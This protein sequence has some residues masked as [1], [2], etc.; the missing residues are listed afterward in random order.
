[1]GVEE[2]AIRYNAFFP[3]TTESGCIRI[4]THN[5]YLHH[6]NHLVYIRHIVR[7][8]KIELYWSHPVLLYILWWTKSS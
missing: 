7:G 6:A 4:L 5:E 8:K 1:M 2:Q 3:P